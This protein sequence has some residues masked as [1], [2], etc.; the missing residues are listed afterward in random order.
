MARYFVQL[1]YSG[2]KF[3]GWQI[4]ENTPNT[5]QQ[6]LETHFFNL[7]REKISITGCGR[8]DTGVHAKTYFAHFDISNREFITKPEKWL[9]KLNKVL[10]HEIAIHKFIPVQNEAHARYHAESRTYEYKIHKSKNPFLKDWSFYF[11]YTLDLEKMNEACEI[12]LTYTDFSCFSKSNTQVKTNL[13]KLFFANWEETQDEITFK[14]SADRFLR[15]MVRAIV[16]TLLELGENK[17]SI[18]QF[19]H[20]IESKDRKKAG[21]SVPAQGLYLI[22]VTYPKSLFLNEE[23]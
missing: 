6:V 20:I 18:E 13:C 17:I 3:N 4:Q 11:P 21:V 10:P 8:T 7:L 22:D 19:L 14:I 2:E 9:Y 16:G 12:L 23:R 1:S 5:V 15:N